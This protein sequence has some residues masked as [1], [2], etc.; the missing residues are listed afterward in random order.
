MNGHTTGRKFHT[1]V[2]A[3]VVCCVFAAAARGAGAMDA[4]AA[5][6]AAIRDNV[7]QMEEGWNT[8]SGALFA[9]PFAAD[10]DY[11]IVNG[12]HIRGREEIDKG[13]QRIFET[14]F[15]DSRLTLSVKQLRFL[16]PDVAVVHVGG[17]NRTRQAGE[18]REWEVI[19]TLVMVKDDG[20][21]K[22]TAFQNTQVVEGEKP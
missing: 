18:T 7:R 12:M 2:M 15:K 5:D 19:I 11:I 22:I 9:K 16:R 14:I 1:I 3:L 21:W 13:H 17:R 8:R 20:A 4:S 6:E 10:A